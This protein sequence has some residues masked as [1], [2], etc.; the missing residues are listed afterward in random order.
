MILTLLRATRSVAQGVMEVYIHEGF[1]FRKEGC[2]YHR[3]IKGA[4]HP[5]SSWRRTHGPLWCRQDSSSGQG[6]LLLATHQEDSR[7]SLCK[8]ITC[9]KAKSRVQPHG[10]YLPLPIPPSMGGYINGLCSRSAQDQPQRCN[11]CSGG[12]ILQDGHFIPCANVNDATQT[13]ELFFREIVRLHGVPRTIV[14]DR[15]TKFLSH[16]WRTLWRKLG[17]KL[18]FSTT[19][20]PQTDGQTEVV[21][22]TLSTLLRTTLGKN[23]KTWVECLPFIEFA[24]NRAVHSA[25]KKTPF[26][27]VYGFNPLTPLEQTHCHQQR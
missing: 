25:T 9:K 4:Y 2:A 8:C 1:L 13:A 6:A 24:Y 17:T 16:F 12:Q 11:L 10:L 21:N 14:S 18:L 23:L 22:R 20:H 15:D 5:R 27:V 7:S 26:E 3:I 19:C